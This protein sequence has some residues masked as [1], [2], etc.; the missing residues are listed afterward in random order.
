MTFEIPHLKK[1][2]TR[3]Q[4]WVQDIK[5]CDSEL[6]QKI[7]LKPVELPIALFEM[8]PN[9]SLTVIFEWIDYL[10]SKSLEINPTELCKAYGF[11]WNDTT[12]KL[13]NEFLN[14]PLDFKTWT[15]TKKAH[16]NDLRPLILTSKLKSED[17]IYVL[18]LLALFLNLNPSLN[19][20]K[21]IIELYL[22]VLSTQ[23]VEI[24]KLVTAIKED[25]IKADQVLKRLLKLRYPIATKDDLKKKTFIEKSN[26]SSSI[27]VKFLRQ[28][29][30]SGFEVST[31]IS[32][33][34]Q[35]VKL[36]EHL[37][38]TLKSLDT[39][40]KNEKTKDNI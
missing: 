12:L 10:K 19:D 32:Q 11:F 31:F 20:G 23:S 36:T 17:Q 24:K 5:L 3:P 26:W 2:K 25:G 21:K 35:S 1:F 39:F 18:E 22:D 28:G 38:Q 16:V 30:K 9:E 14:W 34:E 6:D 15:N 29:D 13:F 8:Y 4:V 33:P 40:I 37:H 7:T 27:K